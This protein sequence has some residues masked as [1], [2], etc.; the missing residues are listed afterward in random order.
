MT[1]FSFPGWYRRL[2]ILRAV[3]I[4]EKPNPDRFSCGQYILGSS[5]ETAVNAPS[6]S[7][8]PC[9]DP[10]S[11][12]AHPSGKSDL[13]FSRKTSKANVLALTPDVH[14]WPASCPP[15][16]SL[17]FLQGLQ[18]PGDPQGK[19]RRPPASGDFQRQSV[20]P[21]A[22]AQPPSGPTAPR[23]PQSGV[24]G[25]KLPERLL[26]SRTQETLCPILPP[27]E[28]E[29]EI[30]LGKQRKWEQRERKSFPVKRKEGG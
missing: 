13:W 15:H 1:H 23:S 29:S 28:G 2:Q 26:A 3:L 21:R 6:T 9:S 12:P 27:A 10:H 14:S 11:T 7:L 22:A 25:R 17:Q 4:Q 5:P 16:P 8:R 30:Q 24:C 18:A 19:P 20:R